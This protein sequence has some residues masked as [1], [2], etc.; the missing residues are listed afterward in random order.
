MEFWKEFA[1]TLLLI[2][3]ILIPSFLAASY[4]GLLVVKSGSY[5][6][7][8]MGTP[9]KFWG[10]YRHLSGYV[11][12]NFRVADKY[13]ALSI[14]MK[15]DSGNA[16]VEVLDPSGNVLYNWEVCRHFEREIDCRDLKR[17]TVRIVS[18]DFAGKFL[19]ALQ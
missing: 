6:G 18:R 10:N 16:D 5:F 19:V 1:A 9:G 15:P 12:K 8:A 11:S 4:F 17:C 2:A 3:V 13:S 7:R 14:Q